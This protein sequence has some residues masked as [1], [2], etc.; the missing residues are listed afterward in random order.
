MEVSFIDGETKP[1]VT[2]FCIQL[3]LSYNSGHEAFTA[4]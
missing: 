4:D 3:E 1:A 2:Q